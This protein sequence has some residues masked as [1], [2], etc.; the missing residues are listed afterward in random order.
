M[1]RTDEEDDDRVK[2]VVFYEEQ[3]ASDKYVEDHREDLKYEVLEECVH[4]ASTAECAGHLANLLA[5]VKVQ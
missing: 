4:G 2:G 5:Q 3:D 1:Y